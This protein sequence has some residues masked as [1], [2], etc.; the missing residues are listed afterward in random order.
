MD[1]GT[2]IRLYDPQRKPPDWVDLMQPTDCAVFLKNRTT[3][4]PLASDGRE[5]AGTA[6]ATCILFKS[7]DTA[8]RF[9]DGKVKQLPEVRCEIYDAHGLASPPLA[10]VLHPEFQGEEEDG[11]IWQQRRKFIMAVLVLAAAIL[12]GSAAVRPNLSDLMIFLGI[13][14]VVLA[15][16]FLYWDV[17]LKHRERE[18]FHRV[19][20]H[21][22]MTQKDA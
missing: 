17:G 19:E 20:E 11:P 7:F 16:R 9:C 22:K 10:V 13:N 2:E 18:R 8:Q 14:C 21:R 3:S 6:Y 5:F 12:F 4:I 15:L 1:D